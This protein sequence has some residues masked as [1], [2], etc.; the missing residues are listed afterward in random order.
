MKL[1]L[2]LRIR[3]AA[4][5]A[6]SAALAFLPGRTA[7]AQ[8]SGANLLDNPNFS[9]P[10]QTNSNI[11][12]PGMAKDN[13]ITPRA[14]TAFWTCKNDAE[15]NQDQINRDPEFRLMTADVSEQQPRVRSYPTSA[16]FFNF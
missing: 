15:K 11:C 5:A 1:K 16:S 2:E 10:A 12:A 9:W 4:V 3:A 6:L 8:S 7:A 14:W 13:A